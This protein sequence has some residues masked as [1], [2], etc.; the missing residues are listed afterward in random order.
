MT[1]FRTWFDSKFISFR[2]LSPS[3]AN[4]TWV[5]RAARQQDAVQ[6]GGWFQTGFVG[7]GVEKKRTWSCAC[8]DESSWWYWV[9]HDMEAM[10]VYRDRLLLHT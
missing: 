9:M 10:E 6:A 1:R 8:H 3:R 4:R 5:Q 7:H 2:E